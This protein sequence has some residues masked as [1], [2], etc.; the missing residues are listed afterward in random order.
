MVAIVSVFVVGCHKA[1][2]AEPTTEPAA[3][4]EGPTT[5]ATL[6]ADAVRRYGVVVGHAERRTLVPTVTVPARVSFDLEHVSHVG[7]AVTGRVAELRVRLG[8]AVS[9]G[10]VL[11]T[12]DS[13]DVGEAE[14]DYLQKRAAAAVAGPAVTRARASVE[15]AERLMHDSQGVTLTEV[16]RRQGEL[17]TAE[18]AAHTADAALTAARGR[19]RMLGVGDDVVTAIDDKGTVDSRYTVRSPLAGHIVRQEVTRGELVRPDQPSLM[20]V[21][22]LSTLWVIADVPQVDVGGVGVGAKARVLSAGPAVV[23]TV[24]YIA[25][26]VEELTRTAQV[27]LAVT[28]PTPLRAGMFVRAEIE[29]RGGGEPVVAVPDGAVLMIDGTTCVFVPIGDGAFEK[30]PVAVGPA[31]GGWVPIV[32]GLGDGDAVVVSGG[33]ILKAELGKGSVEE[34]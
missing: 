10:D 27:R 2:K 24:A 12:V 26:Q 15:R 34:D 17:A 4:A 11:M 32:S 31:V 7:V 33:F 3:A 5:R 16:Q 30:R 28:G 29:T 20:T 25:P 9:A 18:G 6:S 22:D 21:A 8:D 19:L 14:A 13:P 1:D 23:A